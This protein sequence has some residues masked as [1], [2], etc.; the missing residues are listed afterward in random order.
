MWI[1]IAHNR[2]HSNALN[3][4][5]LVE[6]EDNRW[7]HSHQI[8]THQRHYADEW[9]QQNPFERW[10]NAAVPSVLLITVISSTGYHVSIL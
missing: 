3:T 8:T 2:K 10:Q 4:L 7:C 6:E 1:Y 5:I 9:A